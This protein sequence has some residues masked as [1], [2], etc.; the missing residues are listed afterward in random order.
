MPM[1]DKPL[2]ELKDYMGISPK[3]KDFSQ[4]WEENLR[5]L[6]NIKLD[7]YIKEADFKCPF[8]TCYDLY[9]T[10]TNGARVYSKLI[11]PNIIKGKIPAIIE[12]HGYQGSSGDWS[13]YFK[14]AASGICIVAMDCRG[15]AGKSEDVGGVKG[16]TVKGHI[17]RGL[18]EG[19]DKLLYKDIYLDT[20]ILAKIIKEMDFVDKNRVA[21]MG[22]SQGG[23]LALAC[24]ALDSD[25]KKVFA[26]YP[27]LSDFKR[28]W[29][30][31][32]GGEAYDELKRYFK[33]ID[34]THESEEFVFN[35]LGYID[36]QNLASRIKGEVTMATGL[37]DDICPPSTQFAI[38]NK[39]EAKKNIIVYPEYGH[40]AINCGLEDKI[41]KWALEI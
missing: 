33:F 36:I 19:K 17:V 37:M 34:P 41:Y 2:N 21:T 24:A 11:K 15:Q 7:V 29:E 6:D 8:A 39:I 10:G 9:F 40:E 30:M 16:I 12:F 1:I 38:Y 4:Y 3:P 14:Y 31:D 23:A 13:K 28:V 27:F 25:I 26:L 35:T 5:R 18:Q 20:V 32:L 22:G